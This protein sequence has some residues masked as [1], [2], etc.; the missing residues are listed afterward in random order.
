MSLFRDTNQGSSSSRSGS[1]SAKRLLQTFAFDRLFS[2][3]GNRELTPLRRKALQCVWLIVKLTLVVGISY[4]VRETV[5]PA[6]KIIT[7]GQCMGSLP[8]SSAMLKTATLLFFTAGAITCIVFFG[9]DL[10]VLMRYLGVALSRRR[11]LLL[12]AACLVMAPLV[13]AALCGSV[14]TLIDAPFP[15]SLGSSVHIISSARMDTWGL[16]DF[17]EAATRFIAG[18]I[19][20]EL[21]F[22]GAVFFVLLRLFGKWPAIVGTSLAWSCAHGFGSGRFVFCF[23]FLGHFFVGLL[24]CW[25]LI[26]TRRL[27]WPIL[28]HCMNNTRI[29]FLTIVWPSMGLII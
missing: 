7:S 5:V 27:R 2:R 26:K 19:S 24:H 16:T 13:R 22:R 6:L 28:F 11:S 12:V 18:P 15:R 21:V 10:R 25:L 8:P 17:L 14:A 23:S 20:E 29:C 3:L 4:L 9:Q 1:A